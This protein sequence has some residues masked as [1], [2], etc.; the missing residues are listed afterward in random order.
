MARSSGTTTKAAK[1]AAPSSAASEAA[2]AGP[3]ATPTPADTPPSESPAAVGPSSV[4]AL[5]DKALAGFLAVLAHRP[6]ER[7]GLGDV[8]TEAGLSL[9]ELRGAFGSTFDLLAAFVRD[10]DA[11]V[12]A[13]PTDD[14]ADQP[15]RDRLFDVL[16]RRLDVL[17]P[18]RP[19]LRS[20]AESARRNPFF[21]L[22]LNR[23]AV[24]SQQWM[25]A[26]AKIDTAG[27]KGAVR[28]QG[29]ALVFARVLQTYLRDEDPGLAPTMA[30]LDRELAKGERALG[31]LEGAVGLAT[32]G[33]RGRR[34]S[35]PPPSSETPAAA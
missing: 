27:L 34:S 23:L 7:I 30:A 2:P 6:F 32:G 9:A 26:A 33:R 35:A 1:V 8:A 18:H 3:S 14:M 22:A 25:L 11:K 29:L 20:L 17:A 4:Q 31:L 13:G 19:A 12:L 10:T 24:R 5:R 28:A 16:M 15:A 21:A